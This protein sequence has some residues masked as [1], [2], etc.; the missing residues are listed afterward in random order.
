MKIRKYYELEMETMKRGELE[1]L[2]LR[3]LKQQLR[4]CYRVSEFYRQKFKEAGIKP[5]DIRSL[6]DVIHL[7]FVTKDELREEQQAHP[8]FGRY[9]VAPPETWA[10]LHPSTGTT[11]VPVNTIWSCGDVKH[12]SNWTARTMWTF[13]ARPRDI[14]QTAFSYGLWIAG[15][16]THYAAKE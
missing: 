8:P 3:R 2:Q 9:T 5:D 16:S 10:E 15:M 1:A 14:I 12:I 6:D 4:R 13:G 11:G 7:P